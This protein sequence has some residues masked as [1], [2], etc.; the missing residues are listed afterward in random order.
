MGDPRRFELVGDGTGTWRN[1]AGMPMPEFAG[2][3]DV[4]LAIAPFTTT[5]SATPGWP[6]ART[7]SRPSTE[8]SCGTSTSTNTVWLSR[9]RVF[10]AA[11]CESAR[12]GSPTRRDG[13]QP[14]VLVVVPFVAG[15]QMALV[16]VVDVVLVWYGRVPAGL[17]VLVHMLLRSNVLAGQA[18]LGL[19]PGY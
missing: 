2:A 12:V 7:G 18:F 15:V 16:Q 17:V 6:S 1:D 3:I 14:S 5:R 4:D 19:L 9:T 11:I 13:C 8:A 10:S